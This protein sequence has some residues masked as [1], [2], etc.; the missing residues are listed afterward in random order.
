[1]P[2]LED[3]ALTTGTLGKSKRNSR[4]PLSVSTTLSD[5]PPAYYFPVDYVHCEKGIFI[6]YISGPKA[7][8]KDAFITH[9]ERRQKKNKA[10][11]LLVPLENI[12]DQKQTPLAGMVFHS[13]RCG[14]TLLCNM[15]DTLSDCYVVRESDIFNK[16]LND[17]AL[18][19]QDKTLLFHTVLNSF[20]HYASSLSTQCVIKFSSHCVFQ[21]PYILE[22]LPQTPWIYLH[23]KPAEVISSLISKPPDWVSSEFLQR[24]AGLSNENIPAQRE[25]KAALILHYYFKQ[26]VESLQN[27]NKSLLVS[28]EQL[29]SDSEQL[30]SE[31][32][33]HF[34]F[35]ASGKTTEMLKCRDLN[36]K[37]GEPWQSISAADRSN[38][39]PTSDETQNKIE[40]ACRKFCRRDYE[41]LRKRAK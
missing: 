12:A 21:L 9:T 2:T 8:P 13:A 27:E 39:S 5:V 34:G 30:V 40:Q 18:S 33:D 37:T 25:E 41:A 11:S 22:Q 14:S 28:Y 31:I 3:C 24:I 36:A 17:S 7:K 23:R 4:Q 6:Y 10:H 26:V 16:L 15:L 32:T 20:G 29:L 38:K 19:H 35:D 1:M